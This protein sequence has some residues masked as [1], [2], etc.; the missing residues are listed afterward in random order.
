MFWAFGYRK[1]LPWLKLISAPTTSFSLVES[2]NL[3]TKNWKTEPALKNP[4][5]CSS[6]IAVKNKI[7]NI[8]GSRLSVLVGRLSSTRL[9]S[10]DE[11]NCFST[12]NS[13]WEVITKMKVSRHHCHL[14]EKSFDANI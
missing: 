1:K 10:S 2:Y 11:I 8:G 13:Q 9:S 7:Y 3:S 5:M 6:A 12:E 14:Q 4:L